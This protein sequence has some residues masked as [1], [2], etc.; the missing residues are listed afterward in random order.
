M[1]ANRI[2]NLLQQEQPISTNLNMKLAIAFLLALSTS[3]TEAFM[4]ALGV[5]S[6]PGSALKSMP[7][8]SEDGPAHDGALG[9]PRD[10][11]NT[12]VIPGMDDM[13][14]DEYQAA[15]ANSVIERSREQRYAGKARGNKLA[16]DYMAGLSGTT[17]KSASIFGRSNDQG[18]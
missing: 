11:A 5:K 17:D 6:T 4:P 8:E 15:L 9:Q 12:Y 7:T 3:S 18:N 14:P 1:I 16:H 2:Q 13:T 10:T